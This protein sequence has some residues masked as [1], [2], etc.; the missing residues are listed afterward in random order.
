MCSRNLSPVSTCC[1][2]TAPARVAS[3]VLPHAPGAEWEHAADRALG[4]LGTLGALGLAG[5][6][7]SRGFRLLLLGGLRADDSAGP[8]GLRISG[9]SRERL[10]DR[11]HSARG[12]AGSCGRAVPGGH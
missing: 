8:P 4:A 5:H 1:L 6:S 9:P 7:R 3:V 11:L 12:K 2:D 10:L